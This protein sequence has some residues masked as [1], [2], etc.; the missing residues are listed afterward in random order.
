M[1]FRKALNVD[2]MRSLARRRLPRGIFEYV[3]RGT[4]D[5]V[6][7]RANRQ[8]F[9]ALKLHPSVLV[10]VSERHQQTEVF[11]LRQAMPLVIAPT[12][13]AGL[14][15]HDGE[16]HLARA[17]A[18]AGIPFCV[19]TQSITAIERI[20]ESGAH[21]WFQLYVWRD[22]TLTHQLIERARAAGAETLI[23]TADTVISPKREYNQRNGFGIPLK[24]SVRGALDVATHPRWLW[25]V[26]LRYMRTEGMPV[27]AHYPPELRTAITSAAASE[28][29]RLSDAMTWTDLCELRRL[30]P[31]RLVVKGIMRVDDAL[32]AAECGVDGIVVSNHG[33][34][35]LDIVPAPVEVLPR[36]AESVGERLTVM[37]DSGVRRGSDIAKLLALGAKAVL[38]GRSVLYGVAAG[39]EAGATHVLD[40]LRQEID[41]T[42][43]LLGCLSVAE[44]RGR[45]RDE[46]AASSPWKAAG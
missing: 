20:A 43:A 12:A 35:N 9:D 21:L 46:T 2:D 27:Y 19:S 1:T 6:S 44:L 14:M 17:A 18:A 7:L 45:Q 16:I 3:D 40:L 24:P 38:V 11:G 36:I 5:E 34:R 4:E 26:L 32:K 30:W 15:W 8:A 37:A 25:T 13:A 10:D 29:V 41:N 22:R 39:G 33:G 31:G 23:L 42:M 28:A